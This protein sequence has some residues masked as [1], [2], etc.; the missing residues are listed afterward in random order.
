MA[1]A[2]R[3][4]AFNGPDVGGHAF[5]SGNFNLET[6]GYKAPRVTGSMSMNLDK[7]SSVRVGG[8]YQRP[9]T[10]GSPSDWGARVT[11]RRA[12]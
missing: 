4:F 5:P 1:D 9:D 7:D 8:T 6:E 10:A 11:Y 12:F 3:K 2:D